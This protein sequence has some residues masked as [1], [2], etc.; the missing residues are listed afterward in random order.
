M[1]GH[2]AA[3]YW[4]HKVVKERGLEAAGSSQSKMPF[5]WSYLR[6]PICIPA[7]GCHDSGYLCFLEC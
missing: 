1:L 6:G 7:R 5:G 2:V 4:L 3:T